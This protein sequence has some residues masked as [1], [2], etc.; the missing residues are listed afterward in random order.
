[1]DAL[2]LA[3]SQGA[4]LGELFQMCIPK[5]E[6]TPRIT[7]VTIQRP[8]EI[9][10]HLRV[11]SDLY[12]AKTGKRP[13]VFMAN[14]GP[15]KQHKARADFSRGFF[16]VAGFEMLSNYGFHSVD[17]AAEAAIISRAPVVVIC[18]TDATYPDIVPVLTQKIKSAVPDTIVV[19]AGYPKD[20]VETFKQAGV[21]EFI[22]LRSNV[23]DTLAQI[24]KTLDIL[25]DA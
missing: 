14:M 1:M 2:I 21:N 25:S 20:Y 24:M 4:T 5:K 13:Q 11:A 10:E 22:H 19:L 23:Y 12:L 9:F 18:S 17:E 15:L 7:P 3:A 16:E 6:E 8:A